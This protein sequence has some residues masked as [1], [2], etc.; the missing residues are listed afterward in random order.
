[1]REYE[2]KAPRNNSNMGILYAAAADLSRAH[3]AFTRLCDL[4][5]EITRYFTH[6]GA[7]PII[8]T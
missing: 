5:R 6:S 7:G 1:M 3:L 2:P 4:P 8:V